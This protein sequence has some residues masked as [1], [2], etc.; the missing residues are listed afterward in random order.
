MI[1][2]DNFESKIGFDRIRELLRERCLSPMGTSMVEGIRFLDNKSKIVGLLT[3]TSEFQHLLRFEDNF[4]AD[5][6]FSN[7]GCLN[8][9]KVEGTFPEV[10]ELFD[11]KR[12]LDTV[13]SILNFF[14]AK[15]DN[16]YPVLR[17]LCG[18]VKTYPYVVDS[19]DR[20]IDRHGNIRDNASPR[21]REIR[22]EIISKNTLAAKRLNAILRQAQ[23]DGIIDADTAASVRNGRGVIPVS[24]WD[25]RRIKGLI[26]DQSASGKTVF[27]EP[28][29]IVEINNDIVELEYEERREIVK[30]LTTFADDIRPYIDDLLA[31]DAFLGEIDFIRSKAILGNQFGSIY[32]LLSDHPFLSWKEAVHPLLAMAFQKTEGR[33]VVPL[34]IHLD[35]KDRILLI[36]GPNA[37][38]KSVCLKTVGLLQYMLQCGLTIPVS[39]GSE[40]GIFGDILIDIGDEQS[41]DNDLSTYSS[42]LI[43]MK[44]FLKTGNERSL[45][46]IDE[47][48]TG[49]EPMLGGAIAEAIL[50]GL[51]S[52]GV[53]GVLTTHYTNLKHYAS[54]NE[55]IVNGAMSFDSHLMQ[56]L[57][58]LNIGKPG[59][60]FAFEI[61]RKIGLPEDILNDASGKAGVENIKYDKHL[62][63]I[64]RDKR[65]WENKRMNIRQHEKRLEELIEEYEKELSGIKS[66]RKEI[67]LKAK[68]EAETLL[69]ESNRVIENTI[70]QIKETQAEKEKTRGVRQQLEEFRSNIVN[71]LLPAESD[72][73]KKIS[74]LS[75]KA[76]KHKPIRKTDEP[77][78]EEITE[79]SLK[80]GDAVRMSDTLAAGE[81][82]EIK[83]RTVLVETGSFRFQVSKDKIE[84]ISKSE[85]KKTIRSGQVYTE[86]D[87]LISERKLNFKP[88]ID[89][90]GVRGEEALLRV[91][92]LI[93]NAIMV[94]H[95][96][97]RILHGKGNG[98]LRQLVRDYL[99]TL[100]VVRTFR[101]EHVEMG[102]SG[103]TVVE[104]DL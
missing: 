60:S 67:I 66:L 22:S 12:S 34:D 58:R 38:G 59:S 88:E 6:Y 62:R 54:S 69:K 42:H 51:N 77:K 95:R 52:K 82:V 94:Q 18:Q 92:D 98:I 8:K 30:I 63:D 16:T 103:I 13:R 85:L 47:F 40:C 101:D 19:I 49:T 7:S 2:P 99:A 14:K 5:N 32:P 102:G 17:K 1:Y 87:P 97:L 28:G 68:D 46:L 74:A 73:E 21:L 64:A 29:E 61:A 9:I 36:S 33:K 84:R 81:I 91:R 37:G 50:G 10:R 35:E 3:S 31:S 86:A 24:T 44:Q 39:E 93:D 41:I 48:G 78:A 76:G 57:F 71:E 75:R 89:I 4:P 20:I 43:N 23:A 56:P 90:R 100:D 65:Y 55:G 26:H 79:K 80:V 72:V 25:K 27:I 11:L 83:D 96:N 53:F 45:V 104:L 70:R 15:E